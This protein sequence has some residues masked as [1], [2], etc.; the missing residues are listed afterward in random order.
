MKLESTALRG[1]D[2]LQTETEIE[3]SVLDTTYILRRVFEERNRFAA[4][5]LAFSLQSYLA[6][7]LSEVAI[8]EAEKTGIDGIGFSGGVAYNR[9]FALRIRECVEES[10]IQF[11][12]H[13]AV[14]A[15]DG[16]VSLGQALAA[17]I[18]R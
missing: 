15:G 5:D 6:T 12:V 8:Q 11:H 3:G 9:H 1:R 10:G 4:A 17:V 14:P 16:G 7:G 2:V 13:E 18:T